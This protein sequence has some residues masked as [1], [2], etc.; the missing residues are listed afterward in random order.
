MQL[1][2]VI[3]ILRRGSTFGRYS[4]GRVLTSTMAGDSLAFDEAE[5]EHQRPSRGPP[6]VVQGAFSFPYIHAYTEVK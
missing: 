3:G 5:F 1:M 2:T 6:Y 4:T